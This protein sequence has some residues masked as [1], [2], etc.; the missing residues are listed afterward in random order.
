MSK[1]Q[2]KPKHETTFSPKPLNDVYHVATSPTTVE[3][4]E[5][6]EILIPGKKGF[7]VYI[8]YAGVFN[9]QVFEA[10]ENPTW[11]I[12][13]NPADPKDKAQM[14]AASGGAESSDDGTAVQAAKETVW[15]VRM[16]RI[17]KE[18]KA[19][20]KFMPYCIYSKEFNTFAVGNSP[21]TMKVQP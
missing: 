17:A 7:T 9:A 10:E 13:E 1:K 6:L 4:G 2:I 21:P 16:T 12:E 14:E 5:T 20:V 15:G 18:N 3:A 19:P 8:P 11:A